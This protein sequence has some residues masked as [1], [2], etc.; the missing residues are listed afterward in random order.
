MN[1]VLTFTACL[2][3]ILEICVIR[4]S[5]LART[6]LSLS[7]SSFVPSPDFFRQGSQLGIKKNRGLK[8]CQQGSRGLQAPCG[9]QG[10]HIFNGYTRQIN[11]N[12]TLARNIAEFR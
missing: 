10:Q 3:G 1:L 11:K 8:K 9:V 7:V 12:N 4:K 5:N 2:L 6:H